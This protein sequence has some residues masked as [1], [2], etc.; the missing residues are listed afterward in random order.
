M[1]NNQIGG[2]FSRLEGSRKYIFGAGAV[3][4]QTND[5]VIQGAFVI[6][7]QEATPAFEVAPDMESYT[8]TKLDPTNPEDQEFVNDMW[9]W[10]KPV[11]IDGKV[12]ADGGLMRSL[13]VDVARDLCAD[14]VIAAWMSSPAP[15]SGDIS[16]IAMLQRSVDVSIEA[17][18]RQ[19]IESLTPADAAGRR[20]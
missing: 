9:A 7:G 1:S 11:V 15:E 13:P 8:F 6:R 10:D 18:V 12:L 14:V 16:A 3:F 2:F 5:S 17:N 19:Q 20:Q 4:G